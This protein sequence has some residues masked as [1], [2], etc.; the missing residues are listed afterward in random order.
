MPGISVIIPAFNELECVEILRS[1]LPRALQGLEAEI[2]VVDDGSS[3]GTGEALAQCPDFRVVRIEHSGKSAGLLAGTR[4]AKG[5]IVVMIDADLQEDPQQ[6]SG[7]LEKLK[8]G[9]AMVSGVRVGRADGLFRKR[10]PSRIYRFIIFVLF[11]RDFRDINC[12]LRAARRDTLLGLQWFAGAH[13]LLPLLVVQKGG[14]LIQ[15][16]VQHRPRRRGTA[17]YDSPVRFLSGL[18]DLLKVRLG[19]LS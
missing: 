14:R 18:R 12:G 19:L 1:E 17:K 4:A 13:R 3:D 15:A 9:V 11:G 5:D 8:N 7:L 16:P 10:L 6:I 2:V